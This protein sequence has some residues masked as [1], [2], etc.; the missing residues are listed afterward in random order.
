MNFPSWFTPYFFADDGQ[1]GM[2]TFLFFPEAFL[3]VTQVKNF[4]YSLSLL[5]KKEVPLPLW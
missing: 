5:S 1:A 2:L 4:E 3:F